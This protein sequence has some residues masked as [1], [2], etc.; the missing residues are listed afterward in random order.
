MKLTADSHTHRIVTERDGDQRRWQPSSASINS[1]FSR[2][3]RL[4]GRLPVR[5]IL[6]GLLRET[7]SW[8]RCVASRTL[9]QSKRSTRLDAWIHSVTY[10]DDGRPPERFRSALL[11][12][13]LTSPYTALTG[14]PV[15]RLRGG[16]A[17]AFDV[18][19]ASRWP[20]DRSIYLI[21]GCGSQGAVAGGPRTRRGGF[22]NPIV[23]INN[24]SGRGLSQRLDLSQRG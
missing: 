4:A 20:G 11:C 17:R 23:N 21:Y 18:E 9:H 14:R 2:L 16:P 6:D 12:L 7:P 3:S 8:C 22:E 5:E 24:R 13:P 15:G 19:S 10:R 1:T